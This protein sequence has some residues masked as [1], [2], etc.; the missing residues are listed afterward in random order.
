MQPQTRPPSILNRSQPPVQEPGRN[1]DQ[2]LA[3]GLKIKSGIK[4]SRQFGRPK[5]ED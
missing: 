3:R 4:A 5:F 2:T 1:H